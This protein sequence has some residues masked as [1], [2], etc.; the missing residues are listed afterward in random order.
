MVIDPNTVDRDDYEYMM[1]T[2]ALAAM[3]AKAQAQPEP[4]PLQDSP[5]TQADSD[6]VKAAVDFATTANAEWLADVERHRMLND[7]IDQESEE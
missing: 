7:T 5:W 2:E 3:R 6:A 4:D 1:P